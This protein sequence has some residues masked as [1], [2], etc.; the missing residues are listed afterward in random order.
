MLFN[1]IIMPTQNENSFKYESS[2]K[3]LTGNP[4]DV[5][6]VLKV[7]YTYKVILRI[8]GGGGVIAIAAW[9]LKHWDNIK[10]LFSG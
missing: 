6:A 7:E 8:L 3:K 10:H 4:K 9:L 5:I 1:N 2:R